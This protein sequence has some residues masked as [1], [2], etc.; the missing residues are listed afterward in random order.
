MVLY[1]VRVTGKETGTLHVV[2][3]PVAW[4]FPWECSILKRS[5]RVKSIFDIETRGAGTPVT[6]PILNLYG[7]RAGSAECACIRGECV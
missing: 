6:V 7:A 4:V 2:S 5:R 1:E 3:A